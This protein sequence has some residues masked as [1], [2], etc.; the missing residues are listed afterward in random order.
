ME[1]CYIFDWLFKR[2]IKSI[3]MEVKTSTLYDKEKIFEK[4]IIPYFRFKD[5]R[6]VEKQ[7][8]LSWMNTKKRYSAN[9]RNKLRATL[10]NFLNFC[11]MF[12]DIP[13]RLKLIPR[14]KNHQPKK[15][16]KFFDYHEWQKFQKVI[17]ENMLWDTFFSL[18]Y[19]T[20]LRVGEAN[21]LSDFD[22]DMRK[23][24]VH[25]TKNITRKVEQKKY[26]VTS[27]KTYT[28]IRDV[29]LPRIM[30]IKL[31]EFFKYKKKYK[32]KSTFLFGGACPLSEKK[33]SY[34]FKK[35]CRIANLPV[36]RIHDLRHSHASLLIN[37]GANVLLVAKRLGH[38]NPSITL[39][40]YSKVFNEAEKEIICKLNK[41]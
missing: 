15:S 10:N 26:I 33:Y 31:R 11:E 30:L 28:S 2:Y 9:Y 40:I 17:S 35:Y 7:N 34:N 39:N 5:M 23:H 22:I 1:K 24:I 27:P 14:P 6:K 37:E 16:M 20:G 8:Y 38:S 18:L 32:L 29:K 25:V 36:I 4:H 13:N 19:Y 3:D 41:L 12:Y 21:A